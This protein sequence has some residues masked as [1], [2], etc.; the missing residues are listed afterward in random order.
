[1]QYTV[2]NYDNALK[3]CEQLANADPTTYKHNGTF[4]WHCLVRLSVCLWHCVIWL[5]DTSYSKTV[6]TSE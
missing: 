6:W 4:Y 1:M 5:N 3:F 2:L